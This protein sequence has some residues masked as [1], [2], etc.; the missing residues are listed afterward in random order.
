MEPR[1]SYNVLIGRGLSMK[2]FQGVAG[3][4]AVLF[5]VNFMA[6][7]QEGDK[8]KENVAKKCPELEKAK[9]GTLVLTVLY[10][11]TLFMSSTMHSEN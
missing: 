11:V 4:L 2:T 7:C 10:S 8:N 5:M 1:I 3:V 6:A 9:L